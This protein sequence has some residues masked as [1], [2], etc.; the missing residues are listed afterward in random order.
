MR[1]K[2]RS[3]TSNGATSHAS[4]PTAYLTALYP[5]HTTSA[6]AAR[7]AR[8][9]VQPRLASDFWLD[10]GSTTSTTS[11]AGAHSGWSASCCPTT[12]SAAGSARPSTASS[13]FCSTTR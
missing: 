9:D 1:V 7:K 4:A 2:S 12:E 8:I 13:S 5:T 10:S 11:A 6:H 3:P